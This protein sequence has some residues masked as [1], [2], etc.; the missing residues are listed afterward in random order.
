M[1]TSAVLHKVHP[2]YRPHSNTIYLTA[3]RPHMTTTDDD[4][5]RTLRTDTEAGFRRLVSVYGQPLYWHIRRLVVAHADAE[6]ALQETFLRVFRTVADFRGESTLRT[7]LYRIA[8]NEALRL[9]ERRRA[10]TQCADLDLAA[11]ELKADSYVDY[12]DLEAVKLQCAIY[13]L[14]E[15]QRIVFT[16]RYYDELPYDEIAEIAQSTPTAAK[17]N[18]HFAKEAIVKYMKSHD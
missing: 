4:L 5:L 10:T 16:L 15:K 17:A 12:T 7:W 13:C 3:I 2:R 1:Q 6:D 14:P 18:Y 11:R 9:I 8:T